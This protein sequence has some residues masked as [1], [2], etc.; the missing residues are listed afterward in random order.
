M[1]EIG[2][3]FLP[4]DGEEPRIFEVTPG[5]DGRLVVKSPE[6][7]VYE[8]DAFSPGPGQLQMLVGD[9][10]VEVDL[11]ET[12]QG[13]LV[14]LDDVE[15]AVDVVNERQRRMRAAS[16]KG[17][18]AASPELTSPM[19]GKVVKIL[20]EVGQAVEEGQPMVVVEAMKM[21][22]D[23]KAH[24]AGVVA[25]IAVESGQAV[26]IGDLLLTIEDDGGGE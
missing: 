23:L 9:K 8:V 19:A 21:E 13:L 22:N 15:F 4:G 14:Q 12:A 18:G 5:E 26:E 25:T 6:G 17:A 3:Y 2:R 10:S 20:V 24:R 1:S 16:G 7:N 11:R